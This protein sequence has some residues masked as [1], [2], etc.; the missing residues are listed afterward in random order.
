MTNQLRV[1]LANQFVSS[2][3]SKLPLYF[4]FGSMT[5]WKNNF[6]ILD[7]DNGSTTTIR[8]TTDHR[9]SEGDTVR[10]KDVVGMTQ[11]NEL[12]GA[13]ISVAGDSFVVDID[14]S[15][16]STYVSGGRVETYVSVADEVEVLDDIK[17]KML[18]LKFIS[19]DML[20]HVIKRN[21]YEAGKVFDAYD[22]T[23]DM[24]DK[25]FY[26]FSGGSIYVCLDNAKGMISTTRPVGSARSPQNYS[27]GYIWKFVQ[28]VDNT[29]MARFGSDDWLPVRPLKYVNNQKGSIQSIL[30]KNRGDSYKHNDKVKIVGDGQG[31]KFSIGRFFGNGSIMN[32]VP[33][34]HGVGYT[35]AKAWIESASGEEAELEVNINKFDQIVDPVRELLAHTVRV[36]VPLNGSEDGQIYLG[37]IRTAGI[38]RPDLDGVDDLQDIVDARSILEVEGDGQVF[39][40]GDEITGLISQTRAI[41]AGAEPSRLFFVE[42]AGSGFVEGEIVSSGVKSVVTGA[43]TRFDASI[44][45]N[46]NYI[47]VK[48]FVFQNRNADQVDNYIFT[49]KF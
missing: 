3:S 26:C 5:S 1:D 47:I 37:P 30:V 22:P 39:N 36:N 23:T 48:N 8:S 14:S 13:V 24:T 41:C 43:I 21:D 31:A 4:F 40:V 32:I 38:I 34:N 35:W 20:C 7:I 10:V 49:I 12:E 17:T 45:D 6:A 28:R 46:S 19:G 33:I 18:A 27:D 15:G 16:F 44:L 2:P 9:V 29:D 11:I 42:E 25:N